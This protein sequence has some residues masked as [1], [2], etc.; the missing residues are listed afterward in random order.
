MFVQPLLQAGIETVVGTSHHLPQTQ[1]TEFATI[2]CQHYLIYGQTT[3]NAY[4]QAIDG[5]GIL[6][7][8]QD[9]QFAGLH[10]DSQLRLRRW[11]HQQCEAKPHI[12]GDPPFLEP[13]IIGAIKY[14]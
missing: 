7:G 12:V 4:N 9:R 14:V 5:S 10:G 1:T 6:S 3:G 8:P 13:R 11:W 2:F